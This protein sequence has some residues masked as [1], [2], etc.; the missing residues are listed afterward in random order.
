MMTLVKTAVAFDDDEDTAPW[1]WNPLAPEGKRGLKP[2]EVA[3]RT[4]Q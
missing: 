1:Q 4:S 3:E 2:V